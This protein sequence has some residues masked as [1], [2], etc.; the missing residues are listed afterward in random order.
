[1]L[2]L[3]LNLLISSLENSFFLMGT[4]LFNVSIR[5]SALKFTWNVSKDQIIVCRAIRAFVACWLFYQI[6]EITC[7]TCA[8]VYK[9]A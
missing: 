2:F 5:R 7:V 6:S 1:M 8:K 9:N 3:Y 4:I